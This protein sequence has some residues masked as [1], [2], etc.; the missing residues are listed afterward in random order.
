M[1]GFPNAHAGRVL[2][3]AIL[4]ATVSAPVLAESMDDA[5]FTRVLVDELE[6]RAKNGS[7]LVVWEG[8]ARIGN[9]DH[10]V[11]LKS[12]GEYTLDTDAFTSAEFQLLYMRPVDPF[13]DIAVGLRHD[14]KPEPTRSYAVL[15]FNGLAPQW[16][17][18]DASAFLSNKG[19]ASARLEVEY[20]FLL[21]Q[22]LVLQPG[23]KLNVA[24][25]DDRPTGIGA[26]VSDAELGLRLRYELTREFAPYIGINWERKFG[27][28]AQFARDEG[29]KAN[30]VSGV[31]GVRLMF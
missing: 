12:R 25:S 15:G 22:R 31:V 30:E 5:L 23:A 24:L 26:G 28:T 13:T 11:A 16:L 29:E 21:T 3:A 27:K 20:D 19:D 9:D 14:I 4:A 6:Y 10:Q 18:F 7:D 8:E 1:K 2:A 17:E